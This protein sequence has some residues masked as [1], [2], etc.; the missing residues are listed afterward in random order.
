MTNERVYLK[1]KTLKKLLAKNNLT[2]NDLA[3]MLDIDRSDMSRLVTNKKPA[4]RIIIEKIS[5]LLQVDKSVFVNN[6]KFTNC[7]PRKAICISGAEWN[8]DKF[9]E[10]LNKKN[11]TLSDFSKKI[12]VDK[13]NFSAYTRKKCLPSVD[14]LVRICNYLNCSSV[15]LIGVSEAEINNYIGYDVF[16]IV[17]NIASTIDTS[18]TSITDNIISDE[19]DSKETDL[20]YNYTH[21]S[22]ENVICNLNIINENILLMVKDFSESIK[23]LTKNIDVLTEKNITLSKEIE[24]L[25]NELKIKDDEEADEN[26]SNIS[27]NNVCADNISKSNNNSLIHSNKTYSR[28][29]IVCSEKEMLEIIK[30]NSSDIDSFEEFKN[31]IYKLAAYISRKKNIIFNQ[32]M[33]DSYKNFERVYGFNIKTI[34]AETNIKSTLEAIYVNEMTREIF[35]NMFCTNASNLN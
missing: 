28:Y 24:D 35:F 18:N 34:K 30:G 29:N 4:T 26:N 13:S 7:I 11:I 23:S 16:E 8:S 22:N 21:F 31:K 5:D 10:L 25:R 20:N 1:G 33:H 12:K 17:D 2:Q 6:N 14:T 27:T 32:T 3:E 15:D 19:K 9:K